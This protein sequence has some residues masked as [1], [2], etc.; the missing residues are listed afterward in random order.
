MTNDCPWAENN[1]RNFPFPTYK[2]D[3]LLEEL[4]LNLKH[5]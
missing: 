1:V 3:V 4:D 2:V 5:K